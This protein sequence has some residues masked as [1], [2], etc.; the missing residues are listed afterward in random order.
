VDPNWR[1]RR[2]TTD[3]GDAI[4]AVAASAW[5]D[6]YAGLLRPET[7]EKFVTSAYSDERV[8]LRVT[9]HHFFVVEGEEGIVAFAD[10][11]AHE[12]HVE[13]QAIYALP[14]SRGHGAGTALLTTIVELFPEQ[15][16]SADV[17]VGNRKGETFY[18][19][20]RF[21]PGERL[22]LTLFD[23]PVVERRWWRSA[24]DSV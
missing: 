13:L 15:P 19:R 14:E 23:E 3:D 5:R 4:R 9:E 24:A 1:V 21:V 2:A 8:D 6:T 7:I 17:V 20:R 10:A 22:E 12:D 11:V 18:E 16:I